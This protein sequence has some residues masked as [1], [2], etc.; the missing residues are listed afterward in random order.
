MNEYDNGLTQNY[1][2]LC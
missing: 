2:K 1:L